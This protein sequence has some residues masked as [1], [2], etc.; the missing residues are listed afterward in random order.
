MK[1]TGIFTQSKFEIKFQHYNEPI[2]LCPFGD[3]HRS[4]PLCHVEKWK[5][6]L[7][8]LKALPNSYFLG[9]GDYDDLM[10]TS[11]RH[12][13]LNPN[14]HDSTMTTHEKFYRE[15][16]E[17]FAK[18]IEF[19]NGRIIG[20]I[21]GNHY[22]Q[23][24]D[25]TTSTQYLCQLTGA[26]YLGVSAFI[27]LILENP[28]GFTHRLDIW[29]HHGKGS[30]T[31][32]GSIN[33]LAK[34]IDSADADIYLMGHDHKKFIATKSRLRLK[35]VKRDNVPDLDE[36]QIIMARTGS[37]LKAYENNMASYVADAAMS[38]ADLGS[39]RIE[40]RPRCY[41][42]KRRIDLNGYL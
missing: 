24:P 40:M 28:N 6:H 30:G 41:D 8:E 17:R 36:R 27:M 18:E 21:E 12:V 1:T 13:F 42:S 34:M 22:V 31:L 26:R 5:R 33:S 39:I 11:E 20:F 2:H 23:F 38:P 7:N 9:M 4:S 10:S 35:E 19:M 29:A 32:G 37:Y 3:V 14:I 15:T 16:T 25:G